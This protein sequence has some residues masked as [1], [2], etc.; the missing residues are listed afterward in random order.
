M[1]VRLLRPPFIH[2]HRSLPM[3]DR[4]E[5]AKIAKEI[6][7]AAYSTAF[8]GR[9]AGN[10]QEQGNHIATVYAIVHAA[11]LASIQEKQPKSP[12]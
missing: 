8:N 3:S 12:Q 2:A 9:A 6:V 11:V 7:S 10:G 4:F 5:A 1:M